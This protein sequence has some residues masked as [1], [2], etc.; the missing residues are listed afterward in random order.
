MTVSTVTDSTVTVSTVTVSTIAVINVTI[1]TVIVPTVRVN[2]EK[3]FVIFCF[4]DNL[5]ARWLSVGLSRG[6]RQLSMASSLV[7]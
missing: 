6:T 5:T 3:I 2:F 1:N 4:D 7:E